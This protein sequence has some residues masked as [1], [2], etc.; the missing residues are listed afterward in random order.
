MSLLRP[1]LRRVA[2][3]LQHLDS[4]FLGAQQTFSAAAIPDPVGLQLA[5]VNLDHVSLCLM[6]AM[7]SLELSQH[8]ARKRALKAPQRRVP[9]GRRAAI[10]A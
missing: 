9:P 3:V 7:L 5:P 6:G 2:Q 1:S 4:G 8:A 10:T